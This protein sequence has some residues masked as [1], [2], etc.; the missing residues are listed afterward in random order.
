MHRHGVNFASQYT[1]G[2]RGEKKS[3]ENT[4]PDVILLGAAL[5]E[6]AR[7]R[8]TP[9]GGCSDLW[10]RRLLDYL[11][12]VQPRRR[13]SVSSFTPCSAGRV[14]QLVVREV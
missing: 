7:C 8:N 1:K 6:E 13:V 12:R 4:Y 2:M 5:A 10:R 3:S 9:S 11:A 14:A